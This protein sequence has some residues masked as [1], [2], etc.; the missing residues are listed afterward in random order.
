ML[1]LYVFSF[2]LID[3]LPSL[4]ESERPASS[5]EFAL[6][7]VWE[8]VRKFRCEEDVFGLEIALWGGWNGVWKLHCTES[9]SVFG[10][11]SLRS[12]EHV[13]K[14]Y[15]EESEFRIC[16]DAS[17]ELGLDIAKRRTGSVF[18]TCIVQRLE[19]GTQTERSLKVWLEITLCRVWKCVWKNM[20]KT[21]CEESENMFRN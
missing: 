14:L 15:L 18:V 2:L 17:L 10:N 4:E 3:C 19:T 21:H 16:T 1:A 5:L 13:W 8:C 9:E 20:Q 6:R 11:Y 7:R 12:L